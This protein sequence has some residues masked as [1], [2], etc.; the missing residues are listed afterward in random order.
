MSRIPV[1]TMTFGALLFAAPRIDAAD[2]PADKGDY[3]SRIYLANADG[4]GMK[5]LLDLPEYREQGSPAWS[6]DGKLIAFD[7]WRTQMGER[8]DAAKVILVNADGTNP[9]VLG[10]GAMPSFSPRGNRIA[11]SRYNA[12]NGV[13]VM[14]V[15]EPDASL[16]LDNQ[17]WGAC[18]SP[19]GQRIAYATWPGP[20]GQ[21]ANLVVYDLVEGTREQLFDAA[22]ARYRSFSWNFKWSPDGRRIVF[23]GERN[24]GKVEM[25]IVDAR[26]AKHGLVTRFEANVS[27]NF[28]FRPDGRQIL[29]S[30]QKA[31]AGPVGQLYAVDP[32]TKD[33]PERLPGQDPTRSNSGGAFSPDGKRLAMVSKPPAK[34]KEKANPE[35]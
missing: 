4:S 19:D 25:G 26:G 12:N 35:K 8:L 18:W 31:G 20:R 23:R 5:P 27:A 22:N 14:S 34:K 10:D 9:R 7:A 3:G 32:D 21:P 33:P 30:Y 6:H 1:T 29:F 15:A 28:A 13:W 17:G 11:Y 2:A 16:L 24:D